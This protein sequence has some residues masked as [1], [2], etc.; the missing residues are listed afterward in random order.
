MTLVPTNYLRI[1]CRGAEVLVF[2]LDQSQIPSFEL[3]FNTSA[4]LS[5]KLAR[6]GDD[7]ALEKEKAVILNFHDVS[8]LLN[9]MWR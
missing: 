9:I 5:Y 7:A 1:V 6:I 4:S 8:A 2:F 3:F